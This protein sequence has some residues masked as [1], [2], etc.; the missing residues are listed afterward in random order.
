MKT[1][2]GIDMY[3]TDTAIELYPIVDVGNEYR[4]SEILYLEPKSMGFF[5]AGKQPI[6]KILPLTKKQANRWCLKFLDCDLI[7]VLKIAIKHKC[8]KIG[9]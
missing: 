2:V 1:M 8:E 9:R 7:D 5:L 4:Y 3:D 6:K